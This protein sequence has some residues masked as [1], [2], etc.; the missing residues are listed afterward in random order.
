MEGL[1]KMARQLLFSSQDEVSPSY[2]VCFGS[3]YPKTKIA[4]PDVHDRK[5]ATLYKTFRHL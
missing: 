2:G 3:K 1:I 5:G 4:P